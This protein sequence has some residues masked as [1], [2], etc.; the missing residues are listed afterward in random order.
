MT[1][2]ETA[3]AQN[4]GSTGV[5]NGRE[6]AFDPDTL[7]PVSAVEVLEKIRGESSSADA[8]VAKSKRR[9]LFGERHSA[10]RRPRGM[11]KVLMAA[12]GIVLMSLA[13]VRFIR[14]LRAL[15]LRK[16]AHQGVSFGVTPRKLADKER[17]HFLSEDDTG[18]PSEP[19]AGDPLT[20]ADD[21]VFMT[22]E[23]M[24][25][26]I[27]SPPADDPS[28]PA[29]SEPFPGAVESEVADPEPLTGETATA[30]EAA[31]PSASTTPTQ[32][33]RSHGGKP[34]PAP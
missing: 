16:A 24:E 3:G 14:C 7:G 21:D 13:A 20:G 9:A 12:V 32:D 5:T 22:E 4:A 8:R 29:W 31:D 6:M 11:S 28:D 18:Y 2:P 15:R 10:A 27:D 1:S 30:D 34:S 33:S 26:V 17:F 25:L 23:C 19:P